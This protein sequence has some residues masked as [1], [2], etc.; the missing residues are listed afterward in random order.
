MYGRNEMAKS[1]ELHESLKKGYTILETYEIYEFEMTEG[2][3]K[4]YVNTILSFN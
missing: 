1:P 4:D 3:F 2:L